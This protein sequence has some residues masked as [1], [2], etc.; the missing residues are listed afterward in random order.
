LLS[1]L[2]F[3]GE[4]PDPLTGH[5]HLGNGYRQ[6]NPVLMRFNSPDSL[7]PFSDGGKNA[8][9][10]CGGDPVNRSDPNGKFSILSN[11]FSIFNVSAVVAVGTFAGS[12][13][14]EDETL[15]LILSG[16]SGLAGGIALG[17]K[18]APL[19]KAR[20]PQMS[21]S[22][23]PRGNTSIT[24]QMNSLPQGNPS[25]PPAYNPPAPVDRGLNRFSQRPPAFRT[26]A[27]NPNLPQH[28]LGER[29]NGSPV[30]EGPNGTPTTRP[31][32]ASDL[33]PV[34]NSIRTRSR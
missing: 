27:R 23:Q 14:V 30:F 13:Y 31:S 12:L 22:V 9:A 15:G 20:Q 17:S 25:S 8:Y 2:A 10:Y 24:I 3:N 18:L 16:I 4:R 29:P 1:L 33:A 32:G 11:V 7:S 5:Y 34:G 21:G 6:F 19:R 28:R 26:E